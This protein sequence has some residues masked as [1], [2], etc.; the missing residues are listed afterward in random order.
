[1]Q[2]LG[3][4]DNPEELSGQFQGDIVL[5]QEQLDYINEVQVNPNTIMV[6]PIKHWSNAVIPYVMVGPFCENFDG[7]IW[8][9]IF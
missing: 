6:N 9:L 4:H 3:P 8:L 1:L 5:T 2:H 7:R